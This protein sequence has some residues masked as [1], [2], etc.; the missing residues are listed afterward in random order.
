LTDYQKSRFKTY[1]KSVVSS[2]PVE[3][4]YSDYSLRPLEVDQSEK[5]T[6]RALEQLREL[7]ATISGDTGVDRGVFREIVNSTRLF[8]NLQEIVDRFIDEEFYE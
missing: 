3:M 7:K 1:I 8:V 2:L 5:D 6:E 4:I